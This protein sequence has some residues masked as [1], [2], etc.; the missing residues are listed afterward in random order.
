MEPPKGWG[1]P[2][3]LV[4][5]VNIVFVLTWKTKKGKVYKS[6]IFRKGISRGIYLNRQMFRKKQN[7]WEIA[8]KSFLDKKKKSKTCQSYLNAFIFFIIIIII[9]YLILIFENFGQKSLKNHF[10]AKISAF[11]KKK[12]TK[13]S[14]I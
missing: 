5:F 10:L 3:N 6:Y 14:G 7:F 12:K 4:A 11:W 13:F 1:N 8:E 2:H 9:F